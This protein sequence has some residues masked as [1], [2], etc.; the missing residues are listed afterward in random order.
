[1][2]DYTHKCFNNIFKD[3]FLNSINHSYLAYLPFLDQLDLI[4]LSQ[5]AYHHYPN[6]N[7][8]IKLATI[9]YFFDAFLLNYLNAY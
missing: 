8:F 9:L 4:F 6:S 7:S 1:M 2:K 5:L 3:L